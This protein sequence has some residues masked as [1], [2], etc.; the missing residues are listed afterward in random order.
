MSPEYEGMDSY[1]EREARLDEKLLKKCIRCDV[2]FHEESRTRCLYCDSLLTTADQDETD[3]SKKVF[4]NDQM[5]DNPV[6]RQ[7]IEDNQV[8]SQSRLQFIIA[9]YF[10][11]R[12]FHFMYA[13][14]RNQF[15]QGRAFSRELVQPF[16]LVS[17]INL[18]WLVINILD[19]IYIRLAYTQYCPK[20]GWKFYRYDRRERKEHQ[21]EE[22]EYNREYMKVINSILSG[23]ILLREKEFKRLGLMKKSAGRRSAYWN[24]CTGKNFFSAV[25]D[26]ACVWFS[27]SL[28]LILLI[29]LLFPFVMEGVYRIEL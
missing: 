20:C 1:E 2:V 19:S 29:A 14:S 22:C 13:F 27:I 23:E 12:T 15:K 8:E 3:L 25:L 6:L 9:S 26:V 21:H 10:R 18:P 11:A 16:T 17:L 7:V 5:T 4:V 24:L 28:W